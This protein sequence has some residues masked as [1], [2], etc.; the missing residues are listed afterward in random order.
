MVT[1]EEWKHADNF[2]QTFGCL[3]L[4]D[5]HDLYLKT[6]TLCCHVFSKSSEASV[7]RHMDW[8]VHTISLARICQVMHF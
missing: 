8:T 5:Y 7:T 1:Q 3:N 2:F 6:D 4:G